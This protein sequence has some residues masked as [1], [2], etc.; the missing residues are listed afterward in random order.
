[1]TDAID[2][3][4]LDHIS[5]E[6]DNLRLLSR[7]VGTRLL[8]TRMCSGHL[9]GRILRMICAMVNPRRVLELGTYAGY[10]ALCLAEGLKRKDARVDTIELLD[11]MEDFIREHLEQSPYGHM[12]DLHFGNATE[13][14]PRINRGD[15]DLVYIDANKR[16]YVDYFNLILPLI[17]QGAF[18]LADN[19]LWD[20]KVVDPAEN[21]DP[22]TQGICR[23][24]DMVASDPRVETVI[25]PLRDGLTLMQ[26]L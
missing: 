11:E 13:I 17:P 4:I 2:Q 23:F 25:L 7:H 6:P 5:R 24:N 3:Y 20:G 12:V 8:Y 22:Q 1:M 21:H 10:S 19:T 26:K 16:D 15:W 18:I 14:I 9:Q